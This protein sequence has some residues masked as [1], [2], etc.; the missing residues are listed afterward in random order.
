MTSLNDT[1]R[2]CKRMIDTSSTPFS[3]N[4]ESII[5]ETETSH[6]Y[7]ENDERVSK[8]SMILETYKAKL[9][10]VPLK[11]NNKKA[12]TEIMKNYASQLNKKGTLYNNTTSLSKNGTTKK[13]NKREVTNSD[14]AKALVTTE[15]KMSNIDHYIPPVKNEEN[16]TGYKKFVMRKVKFVIANLS[17]IK[18]LQNLLIWNTKPE[19][20]LMALSFFCN[21][22]KHQ[23]YQIISRYKRDQ[24]LHL[25]NDIVKNN[26]LS[27]PKYQGQ[28]LVASKTLKE[29]TIPTENDNTNMCLYLLIHLFVNVI[30][31]ISRMRSYCGIGQEFN[32]YHDQD[33][34]DLRI[35]EYGFNYFFPIFQQSKF[36]NSHRIDTSEF[37]N[38]ILVRICSDMDEN[39]YP[40]FGYGIEYIIQCNTC[41]FEKTN[42]DDTGSD[43]YNQVL[44]VPLPYTS[45]DVKSFQLKKLFKDMFKANT[46]EDYI[47]ERC[48]KKVLSMTQRQIFTRCLKS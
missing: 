20:N 24:K 28:K 9:C 8:S 44:N 12:T 25:F 14:L 35:I 30:H 39:S 15:E 40:V 36:G 32:S 41:H 17:T 5:Q 22:N 26:H 31:Q 13:D 3:V 2:S 4:K 21:G 47:C 42:K 38:I 29:L 34:F 33:I 16:N 11:S 23:I 48:N 18:S 43:S 46:I 7:K 1:N 10:S 19:E 45:S 37:L 6:T 27:K